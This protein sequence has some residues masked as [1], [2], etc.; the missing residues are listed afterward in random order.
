M[1]RLEHLDLSYGEKEVLKDFSLTLPLEG[2]TGL[3]GPSGCGKTSLLR[4]L[5]GLEVCGGAVS[6]PA[7]D[8]TAFLF[9]ENRLLPW[10][11][12]EQHITDVLPR[13]RRGEAAKWLALA[14]LTGEE[15]SRPAELSGGMARRLAVARCGALGGEL[16]LLDEPFTGVDTRRAVEMLA[17]LKAMGTPIVLVSHEEAVLAECDRVYAFEGPPLKLIAER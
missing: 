4:I 13:E 8:K 14:Q 1:I 2:V 5:A 11:T 15:K 17:A 12:A 3:T 16:L 9:Q 10:R 6:G 7:A